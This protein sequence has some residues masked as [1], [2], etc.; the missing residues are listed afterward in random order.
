MKINISMIKK[1]F[2][3]MFIL[4][5]FIG[6]QEMDRP[7]LG[8]YP[9]DVGD[10]KPL[11]G[12][13]LFAQFNNEYMLNSVNG[14]PATKVGN[15]SLG[16]PKAS[17]HSYMGAADSYISY[18]T[19]DLFGATELSIA[20]WY[21]VNASP[22]RSGLFVVG[23]PSA[24]E[25]NSDDSRKFGF[26]LFREGNATSQTIKLNAGIGTGESWN[27]GGTLPVDNNWVFIT[28]TISATES[29]IYFNGV[30]KNT[31]S[32]SSPINFEGC[33]NLILGAGGPTFSYWGHKSDN[34]LYDEVKVFNKVL[35]QEEIT[36]L[37]N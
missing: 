24:F 15:P 22:D 21:K 37:M 36:S 18:P 12:E 32:Y 27:D 1:T 25:I 14:A 13:M 5:V 30:L 34:S 31:A 20:F 26:R 35:T 16:D 33:S 3:I 10:Y 19:S 9:S 28:L 17:E 4:M 7:E 29:K 23:N 6:C 2:G 8:D 11:D